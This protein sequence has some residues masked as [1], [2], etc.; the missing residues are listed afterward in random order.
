[1]QTQTAPLSPPLVY[2]R[3]REFDQTAKTE[4][5]EPPRHVSPAILEQRIITLKRD[6][7]FANADRRDLAERLLVANS[8]IEGFE[9]FSAAMAA[10]VDEIDATLRIATRCWRPCTTAQGIAACILDDDHAGACK[11]E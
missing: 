3:D 7:E 8:R 6:L 11:G 2:D 4:P 1:M 9:R 5:T 10:K